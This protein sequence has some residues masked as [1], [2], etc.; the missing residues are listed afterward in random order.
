MLRRTSKTFT[1]RRLDNLQKLKLMDV[2]KTKK[3][4]SIQG[5]KH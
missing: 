5:E 4:L 3:S 2:I 1:R